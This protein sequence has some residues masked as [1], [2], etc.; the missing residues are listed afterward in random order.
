MTKAK[1]TEPKVK[2]SESEAETKNSPQPIVIRETEEDV[3]LGNGFSGDPEDFKNEVKKEA[4][5]NAF[6][7]R[8]LIPLVLFLILGALIGFATWYYSKQESPTPPA[9]EKIQTPPV[10]KDGEEVPAPATVTPVTPTPATVTPVAPATS[11]AT[12]YTVKEG[13]TMSSIANAN[14][15]TSAA[16]ASF[17]G[18]T[19]PNSLQI[20]QVL[21]IPAR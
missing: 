2:I 15:M 10:V 20:G 9:E 8:F 21:K 13:D 3:V 12:T 11:P 4:E 19:D 18:I 16:L 5:R 14:G 1:K 7:K 6:A 17:N